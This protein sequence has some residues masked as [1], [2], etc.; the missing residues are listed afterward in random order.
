MLLLSQAKNHAL[1]ELC[2]Y[3]SECAVPLTCKYYRKNVSANLMSAIPLNATQLFPA[4][5]KPSLAL[6]PDWDSDARGEDLEPVGGRLYLLD[7]SFVCCNI[8]T[9]RTHTWLIRYAL[10]CH[11]DAINTIRVERW[12]MVKVI[13]YA[14]SQPYVLVYLMDEPYS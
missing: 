14:G 3:S 1:Y 4:A 8:I 5:F 11:L 13:V 9:L 12:V 2:R 7:C 6:E 10:L